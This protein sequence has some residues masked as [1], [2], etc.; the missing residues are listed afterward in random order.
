MPIIAAVLG[1]L[2]MPEPTPTTNSHSADQKY[3]RVHAERR[4]PGQRDGARP[5]SRAAES[6]RE[7]RRSAQTPAIGEAISIPIAIGASSMP[8]RDRVLALD[9]LEVED[10]QEQQREAREAVDERRAGGG[11]EQPVLED[12]EVEHRRAVVALDQHEQRQQHD[13]GDDAADRHGSLQP[14][15]PPRESPKTS[16]VSPTTNDGHAR[17]VV[18]ADAVGL[19]QLA[20][21]QPRPQRAQQRERDVEPEDPV[22]RDRDERAAEH[23]PDHEADG[24]DHRVRAHRQRRAA[25][26][27]NASVTSAAELANRN[28]PPIPCSD[29]PDDQLRAAAREPRAQRRQREQHEPEHVGLSCGRRGPTAGPAKSTSTVEEIM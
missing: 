8:G 4:H 2:N 5:P 25:P 17:D 13:A 29:A 6:I 14:F 15:R 19:G 16:P 12:R 26:C 11:R 9:A 3:A 24:G 7:P 28:A 10:E 18:A 22:P 27:G 20:Q 21:D 1:E 23:R